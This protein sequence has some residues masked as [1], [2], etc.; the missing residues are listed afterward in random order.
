MVGPVGR[1]DN[2]HVERLQRSL[3]SGVSRSRTSWSA[4]LDGRARG[5]AAAQPRRQA[6]EDADPRADRLGRAAAV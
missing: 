2:V 3:S 5:S 1:K 4:R 6:A